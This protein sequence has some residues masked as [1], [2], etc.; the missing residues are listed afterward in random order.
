MRSNDHI[1]R[2]M[3]AHVAVWQQSGLTQRAYCM[4]N[5]IAYHVFHY[6]YKRYRDECAAT[7]NKQSAFVQLQV[8]ASSSNAV[9]ELL[10]GD[11]RRLLFHQIVSSDYLKSLIN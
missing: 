3:F 11:G 2:Q 8:Q 4:Q 9:M 1:R 7:G 10:L 6:W 5:N